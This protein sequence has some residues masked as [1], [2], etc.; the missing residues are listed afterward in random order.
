MTPKNAEIFLAGDLE[1][2]NSNEEK[3]R[4]MGSREKNDVKRKT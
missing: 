4:A 3:E 2:S 1:Q